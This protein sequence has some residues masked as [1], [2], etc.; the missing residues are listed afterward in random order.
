MLAQMTAAATAPQGGGLDYGP[1]PALLFY[2]FAVVTVGA[3]GLV[4]FSSNIVRAAVG[5]LFALT[6][7]SGFYFLLHA[8]FLAAVQLVVY[9]GGT[10]I[11]M[12][13]GVM[14]TSRSPSTTYRPT[15][16]EVVWAAMVAAVIAGPL[17]W[18]FVNVSWRVQP[19]SIVAGQAGPT[20]E[21]L[22][23]AL[24]S[25]NGYAVP[26]ELV[27]LL[28]LAVMIGAAYLAKGRRSPDAAE[29]SGTR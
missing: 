4:A 18:L 9:V 15:R 28:L 20:I 3:A 25:A 5:L 22:G 16:A 10:L 1:L 17:I 14:L 2:L 13:F 21:N 27:S 29:G 12:I 26:F 7:M 11:L 23:T 24:L 19:G 6:G 8:E